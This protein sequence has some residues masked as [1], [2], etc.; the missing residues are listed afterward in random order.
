MSSDIV[1]I[2][3]VEDSKPVRAALQAALTAA[4]YTVLQAASG[5][6]GLAQAGAATLVLLDLGLPGIGGFEVLATLRRDSQ[7]PVIILSGL[8]ET[9]AKIQALDLGADDYVTKP[10]DPGELLARVRA[11]LRRHGAAA[12][13]P[14]RIGPFEI[15]S[16]TGETRRGERPVRLSPME[17]RFVRMLAQK[18]GQPVGTHTLVLDLWGADSQEQRQA[19]RVL[20]RKVRCKLEKDPDA[21]EFVLTEPRLGYRLVEAGETA[22]AT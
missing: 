21:P 22:A 3:I 20:A 5:E 17:A 6:E 10:F 8:D 4:S 2:L 12:A 18:A 16:V 9:D 15:D 14:V 11:A 7:I 1:S 19:L 13:G